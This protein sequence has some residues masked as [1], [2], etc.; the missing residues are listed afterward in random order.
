MLE[1]ECGHRLRWVLP[2]ISGRWPR[3][4]PCCSSP[5][6]V[7]LE[8]V[9][10]ELSGAQDALLARVSAGIDLYDVNGDGGVTLLELEEALQSLDGESVEPTTPTQLHLAGATD[11]AVVVMWVTGGHTAASVVQYG[12]APS[13]L[14]M[15]ATGT[16]GTYHAGDFQNTSMG[17]HGYIHTVAI[18][19]LASHEAVYYRVGDGSTEGNASS[20]WSSIRAF[21]PSWASSK[22]PT[23]LA[24]IGDVGTIIPAGGKVA[25]QILAFHND[26]NTGPLDSVVVVGDIAYAG[27]DFPTNHDEFEFVWDLWGALFDPLASRVPLMTAVSIVNRTC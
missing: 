23:R 8:R 21:T 17:F 5:C 2:L 1:V 14:S 12:S 4:W 6:A 16:Q 27:I 26:S 18:S 22:N 11:S 7:V 13:A 20:H 15:T 9:L 10:T 19:G 3:I 25:Q 24:W